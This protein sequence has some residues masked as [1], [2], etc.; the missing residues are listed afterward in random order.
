MQTCATGHRLQTCDPS[1]SQVAQV[2]NLCRH[3]AG[4]KP[5][6]CSLD[7]GSRTRV[8]SRTLRRPHQK[9]PGGSEGFRHDNPPC[10][11]PTPAPIPSLALGAS[12][13]SCSA[14]ICALATRQSEHSRARCA[15]MGTATL[16]LP[17]LD[18]QSSRSPIRV[19]RSAWE[20]C[21]AGLP[22]AGAHAETAATAR[23]T[24]GGAQRTC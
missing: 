3:H 24:P 2:F 4:G 8:P 20:S 14:G 15:L 7:A 13:Q 23:T 5:A 18:A 12:W 19:C 1:A 22:E 10:L 17:W 16:C 9:D 11:L 21:Y 6:L